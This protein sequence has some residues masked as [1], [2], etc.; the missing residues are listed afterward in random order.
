MLCIPQPVATWLAGAASLVPLLLAVA[1][2]GCASSSAPRYGSITFHDP[3]PLTRPDASGKR[4]RLPP[5]TLTYTSPR[6]D[7]EADAESSDATET[8]TGV[9]AFSGRREEK[10]RELSEGLIVEGRKTRA[11]NFRASFPVQLSP[12]EFASVW[13][14]LVEAGLLDLPLHAGDE[15]P[16]GTSYFLVEEDEDSRIFLRPGTSDPE[17]IRA[18]SR[19]KQVMVTGSYSTL[20]RSGSGG[21]GLR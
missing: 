21:M 9:E 5:V 18:W 10:S 13:D 16:K 3:A 19:L 4:R 14:A 1:A 7:E 2:S 12:D 15:P 11:R 17:L 8:M 20:E 6:P